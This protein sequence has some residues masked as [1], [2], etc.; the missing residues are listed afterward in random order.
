MKQRKIFFDKSFAVGIAIILML[1]LA[2]AC[3]NNAMDVPSNSHIGVWK[4]VSVEVLDKKR[5]A[6]EFF[7]SEVVLELM[8]KGKCEWR[9]EEDV[10]SYQ[11]AVQGNILTVKAGSD[12]LFEGILQ[13]GLLVIEDFMKTGMKLIFEQESAERL[14]VDKSEFTATAEDEAEDVAAGIKIADDVPDVQIPWNGRWYGYIWIKEASG[15]YGRLANFSK[16][17]YLTIETDQRGRGVIE[18]ILEGDD[19]NIME[20]KIRADADHFEVTEGVFWDTPIDSS[21]WY[22]TLPPKLE[23]NRIMVEGTHVNLK[24]EEQGKFGY[25]FSFRPLGELWERE[26]RAGDRLPPGYE[27][28]RAEQESGMEAAKSADEQEIPTA[29]QPKLHQGSPGGDGIDSLDFTEDELIDYLLFEV[30]EAYE[31]VM[32]LGMSVL[33]TGEITQIPGEGVCRDIWLGTDEEGKFTRE[34]LYTVGETGNIYRYDP[35]KDTW[36]IQGEYN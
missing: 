15:S 17:A 35:L 8:E 16:D 28:Y 6:M 31:N 34:I 1:V 32:D 12:I 9:F 30:P 5:N 14:P 26:E 36:E 23:G 29:S 10:D 19:E 20:G 13:E 22:V 7:D 4:A 24:G 2:S 21:A 27:I 18:I 3:G 11:W 33:V 25:I